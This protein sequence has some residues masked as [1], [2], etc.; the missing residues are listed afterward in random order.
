M[1]ADVMKLPTLFELIGSGPNGEVAALYNFVQNLGTPEM[2]SDENYDGGT[3]IF[4]EYHED[5]VEFI[6]TDKVLV[7]VCI[8]TQPTSDGRFQAYR[9][10]LFDELP[11]DATTEQVR[12]K[13]GDPDVTGKSIEWPIFWRYE[14][15]D[16]TLFFEFSADQ[17]LAF[18]TVGYPTD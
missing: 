1:T 12:A 9:F 7:Q 14:G 3:D 6:W 5:G 15:R 2:S 10:E 13:F 8:H 17:R 11:N 4:W 16:R 18:V